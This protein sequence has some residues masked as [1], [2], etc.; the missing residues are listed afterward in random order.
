MH[1]FMMV[2]PGRLQLG[3]Y[4]IVHLWQASKLFITDESSS[5]LLKNQTQQQHAMQ[6]MPQWVQ[7]GRGEAHA[8]CTL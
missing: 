3:R 8:S 5:S 6:H 2:A 1:P 7:R 4:S